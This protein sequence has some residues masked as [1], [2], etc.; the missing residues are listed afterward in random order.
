MLGRKMQDRLRGEIAQ[1]RPPLPPSAQLRGDKGD[2]APLG[3]QMAHVQA[4]G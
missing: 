2:I 4:L 3:D 1:E